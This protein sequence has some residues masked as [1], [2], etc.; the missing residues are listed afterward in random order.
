VLRA[1]GS[2]G[3]RGAASGQ[4]GHSL[5]AARRRPLRPGA[6]SVPRS[7]PSPVALPGVPSPHPL[8]GPP[9]RQARPGRSDFELDHLVALCRSC[10][11]Q[12]DAPYARGRLIVTPNGDGRFTF[13]VVRAPDKWAMR[14]R[15]DSPAAPAIWKEDCFF[16]SPPASP[17]GQQDHGP[18]A[19]HT[20]AAGG[21]RTGLAA[22]VR[23]D[24][25][26]F[27]CWRMTRWAPSSVP[28]PA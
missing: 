24:E 11:A 15:T 2:V 14:T 22:R 7:G 1:S 6:R 9:R 21:D 27:G 25:R 10:H 20:G 28:S 5:S 8:R 3:P 16:G 26:R 4:V 18:S 23:P 13:L 19:R 17:A 12:T